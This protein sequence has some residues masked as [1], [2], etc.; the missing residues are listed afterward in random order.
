MP[1]K[2]KWVLFAAL[3]AVST[4]APMAK[5]AD[6]HPISIGFWRTVIVG[7][8]LMLF[9][10]TRPSRQR[11]WITAG[12]GVL[13][14]LHFWLWFAS[15]EHTTVL[16]STTLVCLNP[17]W[18]GL[19]EWC[20]FKRRP[21]SS[22]WIGLSLALAGVVIMTGGTLAGEWSIGDLMA[23]LGGLMG[24]GYLI[25]GR[26]ARQSISIEHY[27]ALV[28]LAAA[29]FLGVTAMAL[30]VDLSGYSRQ[31]WV[32]LLLMAIGPQLTGHIG[33][34]YALK[35]VTASAIALLLLLEPVGAAIISMVWLAEVPS[36]HE[37]IGSAII[38][39]GV[40]IALHRKSKSN[41]S[42]NNPQH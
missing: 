28:C 11:L 35:T 8:M 33:I 15:L 12:A 32:F 4:A 25:A 20:F 22:Y 13:L 42:A 16:R 14:G 1:Q 6:A 19:M 26:V 29:V 23:V 34:N 21:S 17:L 27:G 7:M 41:T 36:H 3:I 24:S 2:A 39:V 18:T 9:W 37:W 38:L 30:D 10:T 40:G 31:T 5:M